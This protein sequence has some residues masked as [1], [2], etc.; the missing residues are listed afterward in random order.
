MHFLS[1]VKSFEWIPLIPKE[2]VNQRFEDFKA[3]VSTRDWYSISETLQ[4]SGVFAR[5]VTNRC[6]VIR[7]LE[8]KI[9]H[10]KR[11]IATWQPRRKS[12]YVC[13]WKDDIYGFKH[14]LCLFCNK[15][16]TLRV[17]HLKKRIA[18]CINYLW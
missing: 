4:F 16:S 5:L 11:S 3:T 13:L 10:V 12:T 15:V 14:P 18:A 17:N 9:R 7:V 1:E 8:T 6:Y 2:Q